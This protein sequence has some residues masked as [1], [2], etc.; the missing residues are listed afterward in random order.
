M[1]IGKQLTRL[2][3]KN[4]LLS[5]ECV[6]GSGELIKTLLEC[7]DNN[8]VFNVKQLNS[9]IK[10]ATSYNAKFLETM[11]DD[12]K[13]IIKYVF[14]NHDIPT[15]GFE[16]L[17]RTWYI[18][19][20][21]LNYWLECMFQ[22]KHIFSISELVML[23]GYKI[24]DCGDYDTINNNVVYGVCIGIMRKNKVMSEKYLQII[25][26][27]KE[28]FNPDYLELVIRIFERDY[29]LFPSDNVW[30]KQL[31]DT[32]LSECNGDSVFIALMLKYNLNNGIIKIYEYVIDNFGYNDE[33]INFI[34][35]NIVGFNPSIIFNLIDKGYKLTLNNVSDL[36]KYKPHF[37]IN[38]TKYAFTQ[39]FPITTADDKSEI[40]VHE[41]YK[42]FNLQPTLNE[43]HIACNKNSKISAFYL[44]DEFNII[45]EKET[46][47]IC[48][49]Q[50]NYE[51]VEK[52]LHYKLTP[53]EDT[54]NKIKGNYSDICPKIIDLLLAHG[55]VI[56]NSH[57]NFLME[58]K[59]IVYDLERFDIKYD[60]KLHFLCYLYD[61][62][63]DQYVVKMPTDNNLEKL[64]KLCRSKR[65]CYSKLK[66][67]IKIIGLNKYALEYLIIHNAEVAR[68][69][70]KE[71]NCEPSII[72]MYKRCNMPIKMIVD[73]V[74]K[75][76]I[77][78]IDM[79]KCYDI[80]L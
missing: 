7:V 19:Y 30:F 22:K 47:D 55:L 60:N 41:L 18:Y 62:F 75:N 11:T 28:P 68:E 70:M 38:P 8:Y 40:Q 80:C 34:F 64:Y 49:S 66:D 23:M 39:T 79:L 74:K 50:L 77:D 58:N 25:R 45:P 31:L 15:K 53:D 2:L 35:H 51:L 59:I 26:D 54:L 67:C 61:F 65:L 57:M 42:M 63:P 33:L 16:L 46:L 3:N 17:A 44:M 78:E 21:R 27:N 52:V 13:K 5:N 4:K 76:G 69:L 6:N 32:L 9:F 43:L 48:V 36:I 24:T 10:Q 12:N 72:T 20:Y 37:R 14:T 73:A 71:F 56:N 1:D 29:A